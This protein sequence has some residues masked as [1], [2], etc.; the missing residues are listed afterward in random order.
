MDKETKQRLGEIRAALKKYGFDKILGQTAKNKIRSKD[1]DEADN[2]LLDDETP[3]K[4]RLMLQELGTTF[5]KLG[6]LLSTRPD[7]VGERIANEL[8][9]LQDDNPAISYEQVKKIVERELHGNIDELF[10]DFS[11]DHLATAS[12]GQ[13]HEAK[14]ITGERV[15]VKIQ[16]E[17]IT[18]KIDLD[19]RI[20]KFIAARADRL[21][22]KV[23]KIN[24]PGIMDEFDRSIH[25]EIDYNNE[26][27][28]MQRIEMNFIDDPK[29]HIPA[30]YD[31]YCSSKVLTMEFI[32]GTKLNDV[33]ASTGDEFDKKLLAKTVLDSYLQQLFID[34]FFHGDPHPGNIM[35][36]EDNVLC[37]LDLGMMGFFDEKFKRDLSE[38]MLLFVDQDVDGLINQ[39]MYMDILDYDIDTTTLR[40]DLNDLF[41]RYFGVQL[42]RFDG[43]L[44]ALLNLMQEYGVILPNEVVTMA[45]GLSMIEATAHNLDPEIDVFASIKP[46]AAQIAKQRLS[47]KRY[48]K[49][50]KSSAILYGHMIQALPKLLTKTI[51]KI[52][53]EELQFRFEV[54]ITDKVS[55]IA[56]ISALIIGSSV[57]SFGPRVFDMPVISLIGYIIAIILSIIGMRKFVLK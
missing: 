52:E 4:L 54:D 11:H 10:E 33:Y 20:L 37:Y 12:I 28:N 2:L 24:L 3:V 13:V 34:G 21:S 51:H 15:A 35:I 27:M 31:R 40:R 22:E 19:L 55:I 29:V 49:S 38:V 42:N 46:V 47:P 23:R 7:V 41:G 14:L 32:D 1:D 9:N 17:G 45:R 44:E 39:L 56:L 48:I 57:V 50:K 30:T 43:V 26:F 6:Q 25:K 8:A 53:N 36:L 16:K 18:D 5:I